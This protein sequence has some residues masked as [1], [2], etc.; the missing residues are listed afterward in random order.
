MLEVVLELK[1]V[2]HPW[3]KQN[4]VYWKILH[5]GASSHVVPG[6]AIHKAASRQND[7]EDNEHVRR[8]SLKS[9]HSQI[10]PSKKVGSRGYREVAVT[11][12]FQCAGLQE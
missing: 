6:S 4:T 3:S 11:V 10:V 9:R 2:W 12:G 8:T 5:V 7:K 1:R